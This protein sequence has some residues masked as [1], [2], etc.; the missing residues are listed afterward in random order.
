MAVAR[1]RREDCLHVDDGAVRGGR[2]VGGE[3]R[4]GGAVRFATGRRLHDLRARR[5]LAPLAAVHRGGAAVQALAL[6]VAP[7]RQ[8]VGGAMQSELHVADL[9]GVARLEPG[10]AHLHAVEQRRRRVRHHGEPRALVR[11]VKTRV[12]ARHV[13]AAQHDGAA[14]AGAE[15]DRSLRQRHLSRNVLRTHAEHPRPRGGRGVGGGVSVSWIHRSGKRG[16]LDWPPKAPNRDRVGVDRR[17]A[18]GL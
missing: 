13:A 3:H 15:D 2:E 10:L 12:L 1:R 17:E 8:Q 9:D 14:A 4:V 7:L 16:A 18:P 5:R 11:E 6:A